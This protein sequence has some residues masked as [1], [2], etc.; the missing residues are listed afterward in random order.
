MP[1]LTIDRHLINQLLLTYLRLHV[2]LRT[3][4]EVPCYVTVLILKAQSQVENIDLSQW[5]YKELSS[6]A[7]HLAST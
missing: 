3:A 1:Y 2:V 4:R 5:F 6:C 7:A